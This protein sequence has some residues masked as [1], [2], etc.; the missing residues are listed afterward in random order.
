TIA[1]LSL[2]WL[3]WLFIDGGLDWRLSLGCDII[4]G[5]WLVLTRVQMGHLLKTYFDVLSRLEV[6]IPMTMGMLMSLLAL[7]LP[8][9][10]ALRVVPAIELICWSCMY[11]IYRRNRQLYVLQGYGPVPT[12]T[13]ISP[14]AAALEPGDLLLTSGRVAARLH[15]SVGHGE[16]VLVN[17]QGEKIAL[18]SYMAAGLVL[19]PLNQVTIASDQTGHYIALRLQHALSPEEVRRA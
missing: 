7:V 3:T 10:P 15:E 1:Y 2:I 12:G 5:L 17:P 8:H 18:S 16:M 11:M 19:N 14:P 9:H 6:T 13:W 4:S